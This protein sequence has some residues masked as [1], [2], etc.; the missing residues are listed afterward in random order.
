MPTHIKFNLSK[1][2]GENLNTVLSKFPPR[3]NDQ[4]NQDLLRHA[5][6][7]Q[8]LHEFKGIFALYLELNIEMKALRSRGKE[9]GKCY[10]LNLKKECDGRHPNNRNGINGRFVRMNFSPFTKSQHQSCYFFCAKA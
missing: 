7:S 6:T 10:S 2:P 3:T 8:L 1:Y 5:V 9:R 4:N